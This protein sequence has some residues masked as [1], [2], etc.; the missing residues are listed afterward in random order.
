MRK[1]WGRCCVEENAGSV[2]IWGKQRE[3]EEGKKQGPVCAI[4]PEGPLEKGRFQ[5]NGSRIWWLNKDV[6]KIFVASVS[7]C[8]F[9]ICKPFSK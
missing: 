6:G 3:V 8:G 2:N 7:L 1:A 5:A 4:S 9:T